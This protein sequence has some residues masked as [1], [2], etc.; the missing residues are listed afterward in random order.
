ML[1]LT[2]GYDS[3]DLFDKALAIATSYGFLLNNQDLPRLQL[4][5][6]G[7]VLCLEGFSPLKVDFDQFSKATPLGK[8][9]GLIRACKPSPGM[10]ILD[11]TGG[12]GRDAALLA[13]SGASVLVLERQPVMA[14]LLAD[15]IERCP[16]LDIK[17]LH[18]DAK[19]YLQALMIDEYPDVIYIDPMHPNRQK[20]ALVKKDMQALQLLFGSDSDAHDLIALA[21]GKARKRVVVKW[22]QRLPALIKPH[23]T[24]AGKTVRFDLYF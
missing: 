7:L 13:K 9:H 19:M 24:I 8:S 17:L 21:L 18:T 23:E 20:S 6:Q 1:C 14:S 3:D 11:V 4:T 5:H 2:L 12:W 16:Y 22:P 15:G 10:Q